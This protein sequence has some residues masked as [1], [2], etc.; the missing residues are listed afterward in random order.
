MELLH[1]TSQILFFTWVYGQ[2][3]FSGLQTIK[4]FMK[5]KCFIL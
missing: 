1:I 4:K 5:S 3:K 2:H